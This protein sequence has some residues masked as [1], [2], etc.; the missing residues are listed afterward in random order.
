M[1][2]FRVHG[3]VRRTKIIFTPHS[4]ALP[5]VQEQTTMKTWRANQNLLKLQD[6]L[7]VSSRCDDNQIHLYINLITLS[8]LSPI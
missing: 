8:C 2:T 3:N 7:F 6:K 5:T 4:D 1:A